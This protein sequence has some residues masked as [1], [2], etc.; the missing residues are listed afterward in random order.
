MAVTEKAILTAHKD[1]SEDVLMKK[2]AKIIEDGRKIEIEKKVE[3]EIRLKESLR[4]QE[5]EAEEELV[6]R[7]YIERLIIEFEC[8][9]IYIYVYLYTYVYTKSE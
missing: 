9:Y 4:K 6:K 5:E 7:R 1:S 3:Y 2:N 8:S